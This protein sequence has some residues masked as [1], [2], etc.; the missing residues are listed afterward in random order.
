MPGPP[1]IP[2]FGEISP[3]VANG[4]ELAAHAGGAWSLQTSSWIWEAVSALL[5]LGL[6]IPF[7]G[8]GARCRQRPGSNPE[9]RRGKSEHLMLPRPLGWHVA[10]TGDSHS[11]G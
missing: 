11:A 1:R 7:P 10:E 4:P 5:S 6:E 8:G 3:R 9:L 2:A